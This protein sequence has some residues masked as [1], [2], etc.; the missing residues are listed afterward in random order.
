MALN[1]ITPFCYDTYVQRADGFARW[2]TDY[3]D[4]TPIHGLTGWM[5]WFQ[6]FGWTPSPNGTA[7]A[8]G[9]EGRAR[10]HVKLTAELGRV[11][12]G[13]DNDL[14]DIVNQIVV[15]F[16]KMKKAYS[17]DSAQGIRA[18]LKDLGAE[19]DHVAW[20]PA[21][22]CGVGT[23]ASVSKVYQ[24]FDPQKWTIYDSRVATALA[25]LV[26]Q[27]WKT[28]G[29]HVDE[30]IL[31]L[32]I[33]PRNMEDWQRP[34]GF[35]GVTRRQGR[36]GFI[37]ASWLLRRVAEIL[38]SDPRYGHPPTTQDPKRYLSLDSDWQVYHLEMA[39][40]TIGHQEF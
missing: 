34:G 38:R 10:Y 24:M 12:P 5:D 33:P 1:A 32:P 20:N 40:W 8:A 13:S 37:Y 30:D 22:L 25:C 18:A 26:R 27:Y 15:L 29:A 17:P 14:I 6:A 36:F 39:L 3:V 31:L 4:S 21:E 11:P 2:L 35:P 28:V 19:L 7:W 16:H 23:I 9:A